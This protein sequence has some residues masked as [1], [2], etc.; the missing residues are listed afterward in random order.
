[1]ATL[2]QQP[3]SRGDDRERITRARQAAEA[4]FT[5]KRPLSEPSIPESLTSA[6]HSVRKARVPFAGYRPDHRAGVEL[7]TID[8]HRAAEA[9]ADLER[10]LDDR[11]AREARRD[12]FEIGDFAGQAA[13]DR[14]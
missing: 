7:G 5:P 6:D 9:A 13:A 11:V 14:T 4:L 12:R 3:H 8:A 2:Q 1:M 10:R